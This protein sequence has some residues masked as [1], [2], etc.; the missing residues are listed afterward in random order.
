MKTRGVTAQQLASETGVHYETI[1]GVVSG[2]K[3]PSAL[4]LRE[5]CRI[6]HLD[7]PS[8]SEMLIAQQVARKFGRIPAG[9]GVRDSALRSIEERW[10]LLLPE[11]K[12][13]I[14]WL[15]EHL[16]EKKTKK[17]GSG[18]FRRLEPRP[19]RNI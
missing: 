2:T 15:V 9:S 4:L 11:E 13:H 3:L 5:I 6:L 10:P 8:T 19:V 12:E 14:V 7:Q 16:A 18:P 17:R 1:R